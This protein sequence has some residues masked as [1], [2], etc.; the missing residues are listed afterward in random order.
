MYFLFETL[1]YE[2]HRNIVIGFNYN[3]FIMLNI[4]GY[5]PS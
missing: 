5:I 1:E 4:G 2:T 3:L